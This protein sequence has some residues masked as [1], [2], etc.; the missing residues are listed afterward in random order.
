MIFY[1]K[2]FLKIFVTIQ[3]VPL[4]LAKSP[5]CLPSL[6]RKKVLL[7]IACSFTDHLKLPS[8]MIDLNRIHFSI[9]C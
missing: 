7:K 6:C 8:K 4:V 9:S 5:F 2:T 1:I 3:N